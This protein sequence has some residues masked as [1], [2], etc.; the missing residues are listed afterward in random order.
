MGACTSFAGRSTAEAN[1]RSKSLSKSISFYTGRANRL[2]DARNAFT[3][4]GRASV[5]IVDVISVLA[6][7]AGVDV[8]GSALDALLNDSALVAVGSHQNIPITLSTARA[9][10]VGVAAE[11]LSARLTRKC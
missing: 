5:L 7:T 11:V 9:V 10:V 3:W 8:V 2:T 1:T 4:T 6:E